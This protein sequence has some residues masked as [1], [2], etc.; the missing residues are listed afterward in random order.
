MPCFLLDM[1]AVRDF[2]GLAMENWGLVIYQES[3]MLYN[4]KEDTV[5]QKQRVARTVAH[6]V[7]HQVRI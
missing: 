7:A 1:L 4:E 5:I 6:E 2:G 3:A